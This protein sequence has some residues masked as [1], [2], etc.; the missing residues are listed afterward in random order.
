VLNLPLSYRL[1]FLVSFILTAGEPVLA[2]PNLQ[3]AQVFAPHADSPEFNRF[4]IGGNYPPESIYDESV[5][6]MKLK[7][8]LP[9]IGEG[10]ENDYLREREETF[11]KEW[12]LR[13]HNHYDPKSKSNRVIN[14]NFPFDRSVSEIWSTIDSLRFKNP[15]G[16]EPMPFPFVRAS[17]HEWD[18]YKI[19][20]QSLLQSW[21]SG[22]HILDLGAGNFL[23]ALNLLGVVPDPPGQR[24]ADIDPV[25]AEI[26][27]YYRKN[28]FPKITGFSLVDLDQHQSQ[29]PKYILE[30]GRSEVFID[31][32][33]VR[34]AVNLNAVTDQFFEEVNECE[35]IRKNGLASGGYDSFGILMYTNNAPAALKK[36]AQLS[37]PG[38]IFIIRN[39]SSPFVKMPDGTFLGLP[40]FLNRY[41]RGFKL[42]SA[43]S[44]MGPSVGSPVVLIRTED[45]F[46]LPNMILQGRKGIV[47]HWEIIGAEAAK[48]PLPAQP[49]R[50]MRMRKKT[51]Q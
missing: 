46:L 27:N 12:N 45:D 9:E 49:R 3:C 44:F 29:K 43:D 35:L 40:L 20:T 22:H 24:P 51:R 14:S 47:P 38:S 42:F 39:F 28:G 17:S 7:G 41:G 36:I 5:R 21:G 50:R 31:P 1:L 32:T 25:L 15:V 23:T 33:T 8:I 11:V 48:D 4:G 10:S 37:A 19:D 13:L 26:Q 18:G 34:T 30:L 6:T 2:D 16:Y